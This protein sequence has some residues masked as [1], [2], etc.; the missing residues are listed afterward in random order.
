VIGLSGAG[1]RAFGVGGDTSDKRF[2]RSGRGTI[3]VPVEELHAAIRDDPKPVI[4]KVR[5]YAI[6]GGNVIAST[7]DLT[8]AAESTILGQVGPKIGSV[9]P[10]FGYRISRAQR[11]REKGPRTP[12]FVPALYCRR[13]ASDATR[14][15]CGTERP[16][17]CRGR[18]WCAEIPER[19]PMAI[20]RAKRSF[21]AHSDNIRG[22]AGLGFQA[23][24]LD[25][26][27]GEA[28]ECGAAFRDMRK[29]W[30][31]DKIKA[32]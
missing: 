6:G 23:L 2:D 8:I 24:S 5:G 22:I 15:Q 25:F 16:A 31:W 21:N 13:G 9:E 17:R 27:T 1:D 20:A 28:N 30:F 4:A 11:W 19:S 10:G 12:V 32:R 14:R 18:R 26:A 29:P 7:C 3:G